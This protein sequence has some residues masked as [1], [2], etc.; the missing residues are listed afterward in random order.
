MMFILY[1]CTSNRTRKRTETPEQDVDLQKL[2]G[3]E[4]AYFG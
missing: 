1:S 3:L 4:F 2:L